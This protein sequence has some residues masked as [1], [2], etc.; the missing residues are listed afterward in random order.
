MNIDRPGDIYMPLKLIIILL[1]SFLVVAST[2]AG[3]GAS[4]HRSDQNGLS[5]IDYVN[6]QPPKFYIEAT[7]EP[8]SETPPDDKKNIY[9][10]GY[11]EPVVYGRGFPGT[12]ER[13]P[14]TLIEGLTAV[15]GLPQYLP[16]IDST[17]PDITT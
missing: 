10:W 2:W 3:E 9:N 8:Q 12:G 13:D 6:A 11:S 17:E 5:E 14:E 7:A 15:A 16:D 4:Q 1:I